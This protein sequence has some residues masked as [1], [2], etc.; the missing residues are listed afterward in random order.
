MNILTYD[1]IKIDKNS[2]IPLYRQLYASISNAIE[3][4]NLPRGTK[5]PSIRKLSEDLMLSRT[6]VESAYHQLSVEGFII[7]RPQSGYFINTHVLPSLSQKA[8]FVFNIESAELKPKI[9]YNLGSD[10]VDIQSADIKLWRSYVKDILKKQTVITSYGSPQGEYELRNELSL[11]SYTV[12]GVVGN[13]DSIIIGAGTQSLLYLLCGILRESGN[14]A[15]FEKGG[16]IKAEQVFSD[17]GFETTHINVD[18]NGINIDDLYNSNAKILFVNPSE[19]ILTGN[20][21]KMNKR[22]EIL[23]WAESND[24]IIIEDDYNGELRYSSRPIP[25]LQ[26]SCID[27]VVY[28]GSFSKLLLPSVRIG[29]MVLP[30]SL[31]EKYKLKISLYNQTASKVEQLALA[32]YIKEGQLDR[33]LR[34][35]RK[36]YY[37]KCTLLTKCLKDAF[38]DYAKIVLCENALCVNLILKDEGKD[39]VSEAERNGLKITHISS[40]KGEYILRLSFAGIPIEDIPKSIN[41]LK[42]IYFQ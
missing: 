29:Y 36:T 24:S 37:E 35:L 26:G 21:M 39:Y 17:F 11:Y 30:K 28:I 15:A 13:S 8:H 12:R 40:E 33:Q 23:K 38:N 6:T 32:K 20:P 27:R 31:L 4:G 34:R 3:M 14:T 25:A 1:F 9:K 22:Y 16:F 19:N 5:L 7:S 41:I 10:S 42:E 2:N 18:K